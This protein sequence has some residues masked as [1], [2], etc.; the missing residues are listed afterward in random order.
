MDLKET[1]IIQKIKML[2]KIKI[3]KL[4]GR[5]DQITEIIDK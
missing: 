5:H 3:T 1:E 4:F 2:P